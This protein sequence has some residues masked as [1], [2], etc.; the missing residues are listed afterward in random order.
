MKKILIT[1]LIASSIFAGTLEAQANI[2]ATTISDF[3]YYCNQDDGQNKWDWVF[4]AKFNLWNHHWYEREYNIKFPWK[5]TIGDSVHNSI[6]DS[7]NVKVPG[8]S[9]TEWVDYTCDISNS[10]K[11]DWKIV[12]WE[13]EKKW[14]IE[15]KTNSNSKITIESIRNGIR[16]INPNIENFEVEIKWANL[17]SW[18]RNKINYRKNNELKLK[19]RKYA[20]E[21]IFILEKDQNWDLKIIEE[22]NYREDLNINNLEIE[23]ISEELNENENSIENEEIKNENYIDEIDKE[24]ELEEISEKNLEENRTIDWSRDFWYFKKNPKLN[25]IYHSLSTKLEWNSLNIYENIYEREISWKATYKWTKEIE[26]HKGINNSSNNTHKLLDNKNEKAT[27]NPYYTGLNYW[28]NTQYT[29]TTT[30]I[31]FTPDSNIECKKTEFSSDNWWKLDT[32]SRSSTI[33]K[34]DNTL[35]D[36]NPAGIEIISIN[37]STNGNIEA[38]KDLTIKLNLAN[39]F[40]RKTK[41]NGEIEF[42]NQEDHIDREKYTITSYEGVNNMWRITFR[43]DNIQEYELIKYLVFSVNDKYNNTIWLWFSEINIFN[44]E[45]FNEKKEITLNNVKLA[46]INIEDNAKFRWLNDFNILRED[47]ENYKQGNFKNFSEMINNNTILNIYAY[48]ENKEITWSIKQNLNILPSNTFS[49]NTSA[50]EDF[51]LKADWSTKKISINLTDIFWNNFSQMENNYDLTWKIKFIWENA[52]KIFISNA[53][54]EKPGILT[55]EISS[56]FVWEFK[57][58]FE[59]YIPKHK[60]DIGLPEDE[61]CTNDLKNCK[62]IIIKSDRNSDWKINIKFTNPLTWKLSIEDGNLKVWEKIKFILEIE[63]DWLKDKISNWKI[64]LDKNNFVFKNGD[65]ILKSFEMKLTSNT[66]FYFDNFPIKIEFEWII[67]VTNEEDI[68]KPFVLSIKDLNV[69][70]NVKNEVINWKISTGDI[71]SISTYSSWSWTFGWTSS[72]WLPVEI[73]LNI[74]SNLENSCTIPTLWVKIEWQSNQNEYSI[75]WKGKYT[76]FSTSELRDIIRKNAVSLTRNMK[77][78]D[79]INGIKYIENSDINISNISENFET[80]II[81]NWN[82]II[83]KNL[84]KT[85]PIWIIVLND[86]YDVAKWKNQKWNI[87]IKNEVE[88]IN[89]IIYADWGLISDWNW[90]KKLEI[91]WSLFTR[92]TI[93]GSVMINNSYKL[94][95]GRNSNDFEIAKLY[96][97]NTLRKFPNNFCNLSDEEK[98]NFYTT[99][100][101]YNPKVQ[102]NPPKWFTIK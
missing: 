81:K 50:L 84:E 9:P 65:E 53:R 40:E 101:K 26:A 15:V 89:A 75:W 100:I 7:L 49:T 88:T 35:K 93:W 19:S 32:L 70:Y 42:K 91:N 52:D 98:N 51:E 86:K 23:N 99:L 76:D 1:T 60:L 4:Y 55:F 47:L 66:C 21:V 83:D 22:K 27:D 80:L 45:N 90:E 85:S 63:A 20:N 78:G 79:F 56:Y 61:S 5:I 34:W 58:Q 8:C 16:I 30:K 31:N 71:W 82:L 17:K 41:Y 3:K 44:G 48:N 12:N 18:I 67:N 24:I 11:W 39:W 73:I 36:K 94:P 43:K 54:F 87:E 102:S 57:W 2:D 6:P 25:N 59:I 77:N 62:K 46:S 14:S 38:S 97:L 68:L 72:D 69:Q 13:Q 37:N 64:C 28:V 33:T 96:D 74:N 95:G 10:R 29:Y 92:N